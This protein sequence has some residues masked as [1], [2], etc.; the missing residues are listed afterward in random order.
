MITYICWPDKECIKIGLL[1]IYDK[2]E[3][4]TIKDKQLKLLLRKCGIDL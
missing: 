2:S 1:D 4:E 3:C